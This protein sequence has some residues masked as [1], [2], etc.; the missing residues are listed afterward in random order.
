MNR[1]SPGSGLLFSALVALGCFS[2]SSAIAEDSAVNPKYAAW[3]R[4]KPGSY[5]TVEADIEVRGKRHHITT[6]RRLISIDGDKA[7]VETKSTES[8]M[9]H[10]RSA[11]PWQATI[12]AKG[13][14]EK[15]KQT[16]EKEIEAMGKTFKC[17]VYETR[18][19]PDAKPNKGV[20]GS[21]DDVKAT[22]YLCEDVPGGL[23]R[24]ESPAGDGKELT[25]ILTGM[26]SK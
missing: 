2:V 24:L 7:V 14:S 10:D 26:E 18:G 21:P 17:K 5:S 4:F 12:L 6:T 8:E 15:F 9:G 23:V 22:V 20:T 13:D 3:S 19:S 16:G 1:F 11:A 25:F